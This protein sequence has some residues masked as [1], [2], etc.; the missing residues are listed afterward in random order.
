M[1]QSSVEAGCRRTILS[2]MAALFLQLGAQVR[3]ATLH[4]CAGL[5]DQAKSLR[6]QSVAF[7]PQR[8]KNVLCLTGA[9][10][11]RSARLAPAPA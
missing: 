5:M 4:G 3:M 8:G 9:L 7:G 2:S 1:R 10:P 11:A 6:P